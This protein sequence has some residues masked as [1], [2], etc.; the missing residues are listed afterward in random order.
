MITDSPSTTYEYATSPPLFSF[1]AHLRVDILEEVPNDGMR[2][3][4][5][6]VHHELDPSREKQDL[7]GESKCWPDLKR[8]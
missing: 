4:G 2:D 6:G 3:R 1:F 5:V 7:K 8:R